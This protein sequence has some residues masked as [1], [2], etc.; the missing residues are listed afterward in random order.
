MTETNHETSGWYGYS[1]AG[2]G[3]YRM[4]PRGPWSSESEAQDAL[5]RWRESVGSIAGTVEAAHSIRLAGPYR[6]R[7]AARRAL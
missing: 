6:T 1:R 7:A 3:P 5:D 2:S 4:P